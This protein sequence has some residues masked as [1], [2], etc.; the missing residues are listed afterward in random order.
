MVWKRDSRASTLRAFIDT[1][2]REY[3]KKLNGQ[4]AVSLSTEIQGS[5]RLDEKRLPVRPEKTT[6]LASGIPA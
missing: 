6:H 4:T 2:R 5:G 1:V 3:S